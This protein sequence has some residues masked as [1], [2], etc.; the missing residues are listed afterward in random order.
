MD[1]AFT[2]EQE[3]WRASVRDFAQSVIKPIVRKM[4]EEGKIPDEVIKGMADLGLLAC[5]VSEEYGGMGA[6]WMEAAIAA[7]ELGRADISVAIPVL[8]LVMASWGSV[9]DHYA[10]PELKQEILPR[11]TRGEA[12]LGIATTEPSGG[13]DILGATRT[14]AERKGDGWVLNG[15]KMYISGVAESKRL[16][17]IHMT[18]CRTDPKAGHR[19]FTFFAV[20]LKDTPGISTTLIEDMGRAGISTGGFTLEDVFLPD[21][22]RI[23]EEGRGFYY[24]MEGFSAARVL[25]GATCVG[26]AEAVLEMGIDYIKQRY[27]FGR[28]IAAFEGV[29]FPLA[30]HATNI[31]EARLL[32]YKAAWLMDKMWQDKSATAFDVARAAA[33]AKLRA[34]I[35]AWQAMNEVADWFGAAGYSKEFPIEMGIRGVRSYSIGAEGTTNIM[36]LIIAREILG[37]DYLPY[38]W[39]AQ[40][41]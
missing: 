24:A 40:Q 30:E 33:M 3:M 20:P 39:G 10:S 5:T 4:D 41:L 13:S 29:Q 31:E 32:T 19:G 14:K 38:R 7:E 35:Y 12:F 17:G 23:G 26:A 2:K 37:N 1:F 21:K 22:N 36:R 6:S 9:F 8:F 16:G 27:A 11:V 18:L 34:P 15:E 28:P 25:I